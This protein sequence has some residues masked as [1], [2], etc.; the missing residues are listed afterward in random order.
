MVEEGRRFLRKKAALQPIL[1]HLL[2]EKF[3]IPQIQQLY[4]EVF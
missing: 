2:G 1:F 3:T 4:E